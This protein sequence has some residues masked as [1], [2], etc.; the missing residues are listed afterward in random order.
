[1]EHIHAHFGTNSTMVALLV[2][3]LG[4]PPFSFTI[5]G[6]GEFDSPELLHLPQKIA[7]ASFVAAISDFARSQTWRWASP[8]HWSKVH[9]VRCGVDQQFLEAEATPV[10]D[11]PR[12]LNVGRLGR[13]KALP[14]VLQAAA[15]LRDAGRRF[16]IVVIG[17]GELRGLLEG[18]I[19]D[20]KLES[21]VKL[22]GWKDGDEVRREL[23]DSRALLLPSFSEGLPVVIMEALALARPVITTRIAGI[24]EL[25]VHGQNGWL[26]SSG[27]LDQLVQAMQQALDSPVDQLTAMGEAGRAAVLVRHD[28]EREATKLAELLLKATDP[29]RPDRGSTRQVARPCSLP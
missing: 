13:S 4:G 19:A 20:L 26:I 17:D 16:E 2:H 24:P 3:E 29:L 9:V 15:R 8:E 28:A 21:V 23:L 14:L 18:M 7:R 5:H 22:V 10:P 27:N 6:S 12:L 25:V 11:V 1:V